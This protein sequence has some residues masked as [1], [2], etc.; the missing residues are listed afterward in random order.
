MPEKLDIDGRPPISYDTAI[1]EEYNVIKRLGYLPAT[2]ELYNDLWTQRH[3]IAALTKHH[4]GLSSRDI[5][6]VLPSDEWIRGG[7][8]VCVFVEVISAGVSRKFVF[9]CPMPHKL[10]GLV[11]EKLSCEYTHAKYRPFY[12]RIAHG[13]WRHIHNLLQRPLLSQYTYNPADEIFTSAYTLLEY[14]GPETGEMLQNTW[15]KHRGDPTKREKLFCG[16]AK[17][18]LSLARI[19]QSKIGSFQFNHNSTITLS[20]RALSCSIA[21]LENEGAERILKKSDTHASTD[22]FLSDMITFHD[23]RFLRQP[24]A[25]NSEDDCRGQIAVKALLRIMSPRHIQ[26]DYRYG[27]FLLQLTDFNQGNIFVDK[28][29]NIT[30]MIDLEWICALPVEMLNVPYW[31]TGCTLDEITGPKYTEYDEVRQDFIR[32]LEVEEQKMPVVHDI[33]VSGCMKKMWE[34]K[35]NY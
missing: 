1:G 33:L 32:I 18:I 19:P 6:T 27:P 7:F 2:Q 8:N 11:D 13:F 4:L 35:G 31:L 14:I 10:N 28:D 17:I 26:P 30:C 21:I 24:N 12:I 29:W 25:I 20:N 9:R 3:S 34:T 23:Q 15:E 16:M 22:A 5:C